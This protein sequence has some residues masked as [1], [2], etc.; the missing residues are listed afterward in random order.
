MI[1]LSTRFARGFTAVGEAAD[2]VARSDAGALVIDRHCPPPYWEIEWPLPVVAVEAPSPYG[3][4]SLAMLSSLDR[5][6]AA[7][8]LEAALDTLRRAARLGARFVALW[9]GEVRA[10]DAEWKLARERFLRDQLDTRLQRGLM[11]MR[12]DEGQR[13]LDVALRALDRLA[14][15]AESEGVTLVVANGRRFTALPDARELDL[16]L[17]ELSGAPVAPL[18][19]VPAAHLADVMGLQPFA[20]TQAAFGAAPL[21]YLG[22][23]CGPLGGLPPGRGQLDLAQIPLAKDAQIAFSPWSGLSVEESFQAVTALAKLRPAG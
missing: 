11:Q 18:F 23:A 13:P 17:A 22:D 4:A 20:V 1:A 12:R 10:M 9:L 8:A 7:V 16:L 2:R 14:R 5:S 3:R 6:E 15:A 21:V 19:D